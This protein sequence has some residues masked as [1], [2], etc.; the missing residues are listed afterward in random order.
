MFACVYAY[1]TRV[2][3]SLDRPQALDGNNKQEF[4]LDVRVSV[5]I[6]CYLVFDGFG[7]RGSVFCNPRACCDPMVAV[8]VDISDIC[9]LHIGGMPDVWFLL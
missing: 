2:A 5:S 8:V 3:K 1:A 7:V 4:L 9:A 6:S